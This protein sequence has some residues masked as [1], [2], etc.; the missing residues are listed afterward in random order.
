[1]NIKTLITITLLCLGQLAFGLGAVTSQ[2]YE[3]S[4]SKFR[5]PATA[6]SN[7]VFQECDK[8]NRMN[9][10]VTDGTR[11]TVNGKAVRLEDFKKAISRVSDRDKVTLTVLHHLESDTIEMIAV[12][13]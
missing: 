9:V 8:C 11:Y 6:N 12:S 10:R 5:A 3:I 4:L 13:L 2:G 7:V 1:M